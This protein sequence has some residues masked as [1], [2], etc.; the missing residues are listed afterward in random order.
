MEIEL[1]LALDPSANDTLRQ[2]PLLAAHADGDAHD[3]QLLARYF[4]TAD[5]Y[6]RRHGAGLR[7]RKIDGVW[8]QTMKAG[9]SVQAGLHSRHEWEGPVARA[10][11]QLGKLKKLIDGDGDWAALLDAPGLAE[12]LQAQF[13]VRVERRTWQLH[14]DDADIEMVLDVGAVEHNG[15]AD[16]INE[17]ELELKSGQPRAL[18][19][20]A[21]RLLDDLP[22][23]LENSNKA[24]RGYALCSQSGTRI[25]KAAELTLDRDGSVA[26]AMLAIFHNCLAQIQGNE[27]G[28]IHSDNAESV[29]QMRVGVRRLR[30]ALKLFE[31]SAPCPPELL[32]DIAWLGDALGAL[33]AADAVVQRLGHERGRGRRAI[34]AA[35]AGLRARQHQAQAPQAA[36]ARRPAARR[37]RPRPAPPA[38]RGQA[39]PLCA[40]ILSVA[41]PAQARASL[42]GSVDGIAG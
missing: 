39:E 22:L 4:D 40:G 13:A 2:H 23:R 37:R 30:S 17:I 15:A 31:A 1:K 6:L 24:E 36:Q 35:G 29:H 25:H 38:H 5:F 8:V 12:R 33:H 32:A 20:F 7:V 41:I 27:A 3:A 10:W 26:D 34:A 11:P 21:L 14:V 18:Y 28:V 16:P 42:S 9:G 19:D